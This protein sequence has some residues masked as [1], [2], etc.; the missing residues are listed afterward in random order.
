MWPRVIIVLL[1]VCAVGM[2]SLAQTGEGQM[3]T[4]ENAPEARWQFF[5]DGV[6]GGVSSGRMTFAEDNGASYARMTGEVSTANNGGFIQMRSEA[7]GTPPPGST[8]VRLVVRGRDGPYFVHI[9]TSGTRLPWQFYQAGFDVAETWAEV[10][11]PFE[12]FRP[13][14]GFLRSELRAETVR[15]LAIAA[16]GRDHSADIA[17]REIDFY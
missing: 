14:G 2:G 3:E 15:S 17:V 6:M 11:V 4:F 1:C 8:G 10:R 7:L 5:T 16:Y 13:R 9:R 12:V